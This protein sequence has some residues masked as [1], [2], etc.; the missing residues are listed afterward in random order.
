MI[1]DISG[2]NRSLDRGYVAPQ[3]KQSE[4]RT[5]LAGAPSMCS[6][7]LSYPHTKQNSF[8]LEKARASSE[9]TRSPLG[10]DLKSLGLINM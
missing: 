2:C 1:I 9:S 10:F 5:P 3:A 8:V 6:M 4:L 7:C